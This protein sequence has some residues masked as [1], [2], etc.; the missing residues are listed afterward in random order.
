MGIYLLIIF[1]MS[2]HTFKVV[3]IGGASVGKSAIFRRY[4][5]GGFE[6]NSS[7]TITASYLEKKVE[8][9]GSNNYLK[10]Q[11]WD[12]AGSE[13]FKTINRVYYRDASAAIVVFDL[14][15]KDSMETDAVHWINV[16][17]KNAPPH[18]IMGLCGN[19]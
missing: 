9:P 19:K 3:L 7:A 16:L 17:K 4:M 14:C 18:L 6:K 12:T 10:I 5:E 11:L 8:I 1:N 13:R 15:N 2:E